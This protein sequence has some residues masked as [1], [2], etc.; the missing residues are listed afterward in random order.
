M[1]V[2]VQLEEYVK[3][4]LENYA[5]NHPARAAQALGKIG[6]EGAKNRLEAASRLKL[7]SDVLAVVKESAAK[8]GK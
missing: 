2:A 6:G 3:I 1:K 8:L 7:R 5:A 4:Y